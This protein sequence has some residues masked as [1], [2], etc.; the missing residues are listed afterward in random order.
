VVE[1]TDQT[2]AHLLFI[3][4]LETVEAEAVDKTKL[5]LQEVLAE[6]AEWALDPEAEAV[7]VVLEI[8][9]DQAEVVGHGLAAVVVRMALAEALLKQEEQHYLLQ[10]QDQVSIFLAVA[11][12]YRA[13]PH[14]PRLME[15]E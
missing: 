11:E 3:V 5:E 14:H 2:E 7:K 13:D 12:D 4:K 9:E 6:A 10:L 15:R 1:V 8:L